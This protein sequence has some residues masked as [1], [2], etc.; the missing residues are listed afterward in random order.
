MNKNIRFMNNQFLDRSFSYSSQ[1][2]AFPASNV[3]NRSRSRMWRPAGNFEVTAENRNIYVN[4]GADKTVDLTIGSYTPATLAAHMQTRLNA[5]SSGWTVAY[6]STTFK[7]A[8]S[9]SGSVTLRL[10]TT[11]NASWDM[12]GYTGTTNISGTSFPADEQRNHT[13]EWLK[14]DVGVPQ[15]ADFVGLV[16]PIEK[17]FPLSQAATLKIQGNNIDLWDTPPLDVSVPIA[18]IGAM[19]FLDDINDVAYRFWRVLIVDRLNPL[20][21]SGLEFGFVYVGDYRTM[22]TTNIQVGFTRSPVDPSTVQQSEGGALFVEKRP[23]YLT[24]SSATIA[25]L[26]GTEYDEMDQLFFDLGVR[27]PFFVSVDPTLQIS[28]QLPDL[29]RFMIMTKPPE[30]QH[31]IRDYYNVS[32]SMREA[33]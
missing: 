16:G 33:F 25:L 18:G 9:N 13:S 8:L 10:A 32:F 15:K 24:I 4:D 31:V 19:R 28:R 7:F 26:S 1:L 21:P 14:C 12:L 2:T 6:S 23:R 29:T 22:T 5:V 11:T 3:Y 17:V 27:E 30:M 20:G